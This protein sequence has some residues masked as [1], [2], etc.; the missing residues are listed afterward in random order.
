MQKRQV[1]HLWVNLKKVSYTYLLAAVLI[2]GF[3]SAV[4]LRQNN[5]KAL[6][7]RDQVLQVDKDQGDVE[8]ALNDLRSFVYA[9]MNAQLATDT[10]VYPPIQL[11]YRYERLVAAEKQRVSKANA[12]VY[13]AAQ[14]YCERQNSSDFSGRNRVP[15]IQDYVTKNGIKEKIIPDALYKFDFASP[16]WSPDLAGWAVVITFVLFI[17]LLVRSGLELW[18][19][20]RLRQ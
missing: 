8:T 5:L 6:E 13:T 1:H 17:V 19:R 11:K 16:S 2:A 4:A 12:A 20:Y 14:K 18:V 10:S 7:L 15:C 9:H 3:I